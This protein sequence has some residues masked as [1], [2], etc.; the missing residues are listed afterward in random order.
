[1][2]RFRVPAQ[3]LFSCFEVATITV[4]AETADEAKQKAGDILFDYDHP[5]HPK[6]WHVDWGGYN[7]DDGEVG[8]PEVIQRR[9]RNP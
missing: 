8:V 4:T 6:R 3:R 7:C 5:A 2:P 1:M 9:R